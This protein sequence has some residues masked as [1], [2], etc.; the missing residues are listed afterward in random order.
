MYRY[1]YIYTCAT[2]TCAEVALELARLGRLEHHP[3]LLAQLARRLRRQR[4]EHAPPLLRANHTR[5][6]TAPVQENP[7]RR[8]GR[9]AERPRVVR[10]QN[11][12]GHATPHQ[13][14]ASA[15]SP[16]GSATRSSVR[17]ASARSSSSSCASCSVHHAACDVPSMPA[18]HADT[19]AR[20]NLHVCPLQHTRVHATTY[21]CARYPAIC[22]R[23]QSRVPPS[24]DDFG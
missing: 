6:V 19:C 13:T 4:V 11:T 1:I 22:S 14:C 24:T 16:C 2:P 7:R 18:V 5:A 8:P 21:A 17:R 3:Q 20:Y 15:S 9:R 12:Q 10:H 23:C